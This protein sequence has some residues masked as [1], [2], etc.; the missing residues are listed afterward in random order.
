MNKNLM[1]AYIQSIGTAVPP[2]LANQS[3]IAEFMTRHLQLN[4]REERKLKVLY[5][6]TGIQKRYSVLE[7]FSKSLNGQSFFKE[8][9]SFPSAKPRMEIYQ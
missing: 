6:A 8:D 4:D 7:D 1:P 5:R 9:A 2:F 3:D